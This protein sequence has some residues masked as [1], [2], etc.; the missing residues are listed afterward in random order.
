MQLQKNHED[1]NQMDQF[2]SDSPLS[3]YYAKS[4]TKY[5]VR[6]MMDIRGNWTPTTTG[7][8][9]KTRSPASRAK[10][11]NW[12]KNTPSTQVSSAIQR[13]IQGHRFLESYFKGES[14]TCPPLL[15]PYWDNLCPKLNFINNVRLVEGNLFHF[16]EGYGGRV[17]LVA[18][19]GDIPCAIEFKFCDRIKPIYDDIPLQLAAYIGALNRQYGKPDDIQINHAL[20]IVTTPDETDITLFSPNDVK[21][22]WETWQT[23]VAQFWGFLEAA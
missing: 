9:D 7:I 13:G 5:G 22:Y 14:V 6:G 16:Y 18:N 10:L 15:Q 19:W 21:Q 3:P 17:D 4:V 11:K 2:W 12:H 1:L 8:L 23:R 20:L